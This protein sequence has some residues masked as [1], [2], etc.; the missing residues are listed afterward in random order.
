MVYESGGVIGA[1]Y[2]V[3]EED[4]TLLLLLSIRVQCH[5]LL[6]VTRKNDRV[7]HGEIVLRG[8]C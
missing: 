4:V 1:D 7:C 3:V 5:H 6:L 8:T 2:A